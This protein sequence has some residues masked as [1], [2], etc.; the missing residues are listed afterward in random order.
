MR[1]AYLPGSLLVVAVLIG[2]A[3]GAD[4]LKSGPQKAKMSIKAFNP[5]HC[6]GGGVGTKACLV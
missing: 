2:P 5:L 1:Y 6:S 3:H 4:D